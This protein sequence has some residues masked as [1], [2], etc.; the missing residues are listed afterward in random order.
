MNFP[1]YFPQNKESAFSVNASFPL[2]YFSPSL[3]ADKYLMSLE[4]SLNIQNKLYIEF[5]APKKQFLKEETPFSG[6]VENF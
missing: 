6:W 1:K 3:T 4:I 5:M 2:Q